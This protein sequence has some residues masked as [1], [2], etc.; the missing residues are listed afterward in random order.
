MARGGDLTDKFGRRLL[1][2]ESQYGA[3]NFKI[4]DSNAPGFTRTALIPKP[5]FLFFARFRISKT[6][7]DAA[8]QLGDKSA[9]DNIKNDVIF[10]IKQI[11]KPKF[12]IQSETLNQYNKKRVVQTGIDYNPMTINFH[13]DVG[14]KVMRFWNDYFKYYY[15]DGGRESTLD[16]RNDMVTRD[17]VNGQQNE[18]G[19]GYRGNFAGGSVN[20]HLI[21]SIELIQFYGQEFTSMQFVRPIITIFDHDNNDYAEGRVGTGIRISFDYEGVIYNL[22]PTN[23]EGHEDEFDF[24]SDY[25]DPQG[26]TRIDVGGT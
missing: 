25:Y 11:D 21:E 3:Q 17:F 16:W 22:D 13:D 15:G 6:A 24:L 18:N 10:Q 14:D 7:L 9:F 1:F 19:W 4:S 20:M 8:A 12:N 26:R 23:V 2:R 5:K